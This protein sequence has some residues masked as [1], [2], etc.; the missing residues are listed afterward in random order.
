MVLWAL[1]TA[2]RFGVDIR[3]GT[4]FSTKLLNALSLEEMNTARAAAPQ[5]L[6][7]HPEDEQMRAARKRLHMLAAA[8]EHQER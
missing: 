8:L 4:S 6:E 2:S 3:P 5:R 1:G 7:D